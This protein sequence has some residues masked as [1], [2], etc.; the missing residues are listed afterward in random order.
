M[1]IGGGVLF[2]V[3][4]VIGAAAVAVMAV[5]SSCIKNPKTARLL[6]AVEAVLTA[7]GVVGIITV[8]VVFRVRLA[9]QELTAEYVEWAYDAFAHHFRLSLAVTAVFVAITLFAAFTDH[10]MLFGRCA[11]SVIG[12]VS[13]VLIAEAVASM[14]V[15]DKIE[16]N[17]YILA[18]GF[19]E[20]LIMN[21]RGTVDD[22][23]LA[24]ELENEKAEK[25]RRRKK[26]K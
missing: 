18:V 9:S 17:N 5:V 19:F 26:K 1:F 21:A 4:A 23:R 20:V 22:Y 11:L 7:V 24:K 2:S 8:Y 6:S 13:A 25:K 3:L 15:S 10:K 14:S 16:V 12:A